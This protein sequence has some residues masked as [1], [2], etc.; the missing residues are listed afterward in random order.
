MLEV[1]CGTGRFMTFARDNLPLD[2]EYTAIDLSPFYLQATIDNDKNW[3]RVRSR[4]EQ[5]QSS[6]AVDLKP[7]RAVQAKA[8]DLPFQDGEFDAVVCVFLFHEI[9]REMRTQAAAEMAR[10]VRPGGNVVFT[11]STQL[12]DRPVFDDIMHRFEKMN[13]PFFIDYINDDLPAH[14]ERVGLECRTKTVC[15]STKTLS[16]QKPAP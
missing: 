15:A 14:F 8:E 1:A 16:F 3:R 7:C 9:P 12:G 10:V 11:D 13:E 2:T 4:T 5:S 6:K